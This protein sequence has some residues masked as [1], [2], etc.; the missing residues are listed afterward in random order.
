MAVKKLTHTKQGMKPVPPH[1]EVKQI[2]FQ[3]LKWIDIV[4]PTKRHI[5]MLKEQFDFHE[6]L[7]EDCMTEHQRS[8]VDDFDEYCFIVLHFPRY[9]KETVT[10]ETE[11]VDIFLGPNYLITLHEGELKPLVGFFHL[12]FSQER[13]KAEYMSKGSALLLYEVT[14]RLFDY[15]FPMLDKIDILLSDINREVFKNS[16]KSMLQTI[17][18]TKMQIIN[19]RRVIKPLRPVILMLEKVIKKYLPEDMDIYFDD[20]T[21]KMEKIWDMLEN[22]KEVIESM[23][24]TFSALTNQRINNLLRTFT[25]LQV[26]TLPMIVVGGLFSMNVDGIPLHEYSSAFWIVFGMIML[27]TGVGAGIMFWNRKKWF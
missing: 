12:C 20:I 10:M 6:L 9:R 24:E 18:R 16:S 5:N 8:K 27:P 2:D 22:S 11:E 13:A 14:K 4:K 3:G 7:L 1:S 23:D 19:Y 25:I 26:L 21:D 17:A 15:C